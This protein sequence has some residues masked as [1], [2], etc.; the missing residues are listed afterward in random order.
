MTTTLNINGKPTKVV[1]DANRNGFY[2]VFDRATGE[3]LTANKYGKTINWA[4]GIDEKTGRP[5]ETEL[6]LQRNI[7]AGKDLNS[8]AIEP[9]PH[10][11]LA[12]PVK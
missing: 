3:M 4:S 5:I 7:R 2:Y 6:S 12:D 11:S 9:N 10:G 8:R 1:M